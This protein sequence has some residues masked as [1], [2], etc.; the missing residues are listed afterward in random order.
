MGEADD[1]VATDL[2]T[3]IPYFDKSDYLDKQIPNSGLWTGTTGRSLTQPWQAKG[4]SEK[5]INTDNR[6]RT[7]FN[8]LTGIGLIPMDKPGY[9]KQAKREATQERNKR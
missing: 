2:R 9:V 8:F 6:E 1:A 3:G 5:E 4:G 7:L